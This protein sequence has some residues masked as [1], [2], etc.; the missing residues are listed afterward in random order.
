M[1]ARRAAAARA[2][3]DRGGRDGMV[4]AIPYL[5][6]LVAAVAGVY[7]AW[8]QGSHGAGQGGV[9]AGSA[10]LAAAVARLTLPARLAGLLA[11]RH[12]VTD[13][14][15]LTVF[16]AGLLVAGLVLPRLG[17]RETRITCPKSRWPIPS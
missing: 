11:S 3:A 15:M 4:G 8:R 17:K 10:M 13:V 5:A 1:A 7:I 9:V 2:R 14:L 6:V 12:R 16:G